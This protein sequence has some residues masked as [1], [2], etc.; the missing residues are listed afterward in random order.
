M[1][2]KTPWENVS[3]ELSKEVRV[4]VEEIYDIMKKHKVRSD[5]MRYY[6]PSYVDA[7]LSG[8]RKQYK[9]PVKEIT[10]VLGI[11]LIKGLEEMVNVGP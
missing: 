11:N 5:E 3:G 6:I 10:N 1:N 7:Y 9:E 8:M 2:T 4:V